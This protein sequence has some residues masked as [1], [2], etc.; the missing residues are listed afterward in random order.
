[1]SDAMKIVNLTPHDV[2]VVAGNRHTGVT[3][4]ASGEVLR[5]GHIDLGTWRYTG[6]GVWVEGV[7]F[8]HLQNPP[9]RIEG[10]WYIVSLPCAL[11]HPRGDFLVPFDE[12][13]DEAGRIVGCRGL[14]QL[15]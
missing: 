14:A 7:E 13:R 9:E 15:A 10:T 1:V 8:H 4:P 6:E 11:A 5:L 3:Y 2:N 12:V